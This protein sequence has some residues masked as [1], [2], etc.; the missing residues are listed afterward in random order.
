MPR[1]T[2]EVS[3]RI[4]EL[5][6]AGVITI[7]ADYYSSGIDLYGRVVQPH[8]KL[9][10]YPHQSMTLAELEPSLEKVRTDRETTRSSFGEES[11]MTT[12]TKKGQSVNVATRNDPEIGKVPEAITIHGIRNS[13]P[14]ASLCWKDLHHLSD[15]QLNRRLLSIGKEMGND[16][17]VS[18]ISSGSN[19]KTTKQPTLY[20]WWCEASPE[21]RWTLVTTK[22][23]V[24]TEP[25]GPTRLRLL[26]RLGAGQYPFRGSDGSLEEEED[27][28]E[29]EEELERAFNRSLRLEI[30]SDSE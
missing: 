23:M 10:V 12:P 15:D 1:I 6:K 3:P 16:K 20:K 25:N 22:K 8:P 5:L 26:S 18:K 4:S 9:G 21:D 7:T 2:I 17:A 11:V 27:E 28:V 19:F 14:K 30:A 29:E 24:G 13:L